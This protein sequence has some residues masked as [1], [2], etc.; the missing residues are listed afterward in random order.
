MPCTHCRTCTCTMYMFVLCTYMQLRRERFITE[1]EGYEKQLQDFQTFGD[2][3]E[4]KRYHKKAL[5]LKT[6]LEEA[7]E[8]IDGFNLEED[9]FEWQRTQYPLKNKMATTLDPYVKLYETIMEFNK[10]QE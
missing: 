2:L 5:S 9:A 4:V 10:K 7:Q 8:K 1:L 3:Q 6:R